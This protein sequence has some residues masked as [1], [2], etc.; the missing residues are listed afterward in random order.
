MIANFIQ[1]YYLYIKALHIISIICWMAGLL[2]LPRLF[3]Y[4]SEV[5]NNKQQKETFKIMEKKLLLYIMK[6]AFLLTFISGFFIAIYIYHMQ[7]LWLHLK[8][9]LAMFLF[10]YNIFLMKAYKKFEMD[11]NT[12]S[13]KKWRMLNEIPTILMVIIVFL[14]VVK[15]I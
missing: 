2:Y 15:P 6:P 14:A 12:I 10:L 4:H 9:T 5:D 7:G 3:V 8:I 1:K 13:S 11:K